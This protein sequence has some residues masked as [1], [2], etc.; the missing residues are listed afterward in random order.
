MEIPCRSSASTSPHLP[1]RPRSLHVLLR[2]RRRFLQIHLFTIHLIGL[3]PPGLVL[4]DPYPRSPSLPHPFPGATT[5]Y[6]VQSPPPLALAT[7]QGIKGRV[8][9]KENPSYRYYLGGRSPRGPLE[10]CCCRPRI[11]TLTSNSVW[12]H[13]M[14]C[15]YA[16]LRLCAWNRRCPSRYIPCLCRTRYV[17][18][19]RSMQLAT[20]IAPPTYLLITITGDIAASWSHAL[21]IVEQ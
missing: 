14:F 13:K 2:T 12:C 18:G 21:G 7:P 17:C 11:A 5:A 9:E 6:R 8:K 3:Q 16:R 15:H 4:H 10:S 1:I 19:V 20:F